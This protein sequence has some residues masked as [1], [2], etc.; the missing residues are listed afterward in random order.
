LSKYEL[1]FADDGVLFS[2]TKEGLQDSLNYLEN[3][4]QKMELISIYQK[5]C[6]SMGRISDSFK[7]TF[8]GNEKEIVRLFNYLGVVFSS[9]VCF[10]MRLKLWQG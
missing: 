3:L 1:L 6:Y 4:L 5:K 2:E 7:W 10:T 9:G 8:S